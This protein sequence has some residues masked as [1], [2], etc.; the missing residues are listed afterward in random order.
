MKLRRIAILILVVLV[1][2]PSASLADKDLIAELGKNDFLIERKIIDYPAEVLEAMV[3]EI[4]PGYELVWEFELYCVIALRK[5]DDGSL[6]PLTEYLSYDTL[7]FERSVILGRR[8]VHGNFRYVYELLIAA[9]KVAGTYNEF[10]SEDEY[11]FA[12]IYLDKLNQ[13][14]RATGAWEVQVKEKTVS[15]QK[16]S[17]LE[18]VQDLEKP[19]SKKKEGK[20]QIYPMLTEN[21][22]TIMSTSIYDV[23]IEALTNA[24]AKVSASP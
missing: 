23:L 7:N 14:L 13:L 9:S 17:V 12:D 1:T 3:A 18:Y 8:Y 19:K 11:G 10:F 6:I 5:L 22:Y 21:G 4:A 20:I 2:L 16:V 15:K 24:G